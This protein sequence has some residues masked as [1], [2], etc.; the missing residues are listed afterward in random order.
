M[1]L[2]PLVTALCLVLFHSPDG[3]ELRV[4]TAQIAALK[5][6]DHTP[7]LPPDTK[8]VLL[9]GGQKFAIR[10]TVEQA[11]QIIDAACED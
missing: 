7:H 5:A 4:E 11:Q 10:E 2:P 3:K 1:R 9:A 6:A 8:S